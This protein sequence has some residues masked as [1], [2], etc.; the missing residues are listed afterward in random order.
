[1]FEWMLRQLPSPH[2]P[3]PPQQ[4]IKL[5]LL[6]HLIPGAKQTVAEACKVAYL[7]GAA[8]GADATLAISVPLSFAAGIFFAFCLWL[9]WQIARAVIRLIGRIRQ[10][11]DAQLVA[12]LARVLR[13][14]Q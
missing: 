10:P 3:G 12:G 11:T 2:L 8:D 4:R 7:A 6:P 13:E 5:P 14:A 9:A 1:M